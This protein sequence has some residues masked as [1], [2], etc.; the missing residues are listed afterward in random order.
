M[1]G[2]QA[3]KPAAPQTRPPRARAAGRQHALRHARKQAVDLIEAQR[4][5]PEM[6]QGHAFLF[7]IDDQERGPDRAARG[8]LEAVVTRVRAV[9]SLSTLRAMNV[10]SCVA[11]G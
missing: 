1:L 5:A 7:A 8:A 2:D 10:R 11:Q 9:V 4:F 3:H 6:P